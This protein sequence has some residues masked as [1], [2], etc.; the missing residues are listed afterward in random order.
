MTSLLILGSL[1]ITQ[2]EGARRREPR[3]GSTAASSLLLAIALWGLPAGAHAQIY[4]GDGSE[5][6]V[7]KYDVVT[8]GSISGSLVTGVSQPFGIAVSGN[9]PL[10][11]EQRGRQRLVGGRVQRDDRRGDQQELRR[12][13]ERR[14]CD[15]RRREHAVRGELP[16]GGQA[17]VS[18][19][20]ATTGAV[21][22][23]NFITTTGHFA[24][25]DS[26]RVLGKLSLHRRPRSQHGR[27]DHRR[28][29]FGH[30]RGDQR[31]LHH[32][33]TFAVRRHRGFGQQPLR[34]GPLRRHR[35]AV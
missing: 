18:T 10:R 5:S 25:F 34:A 1:G 35:R 21:I 6:A 11:V 19:Y 24:Y 30:R 16:P 13:P 15:R 12:R 8:G 32:G 20:N 28:I 3:R 27:P 9:D 17:R 14:G 33:N 22:N 31:Q 23:A 4:V 2:S 26:F 29:Q 7:Q